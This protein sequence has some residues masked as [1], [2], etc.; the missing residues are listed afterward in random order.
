[1]GQ[2]AGVAG[3]QRGLRGRAP[4]SGVVA[5]RAA[6]HDWTTYSGKSVWSP[7]KPFHAFL[8]GVDRARQADRL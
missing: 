4:E 6:T 7:E 3:E 8:E 2:L 1:M 5:Y